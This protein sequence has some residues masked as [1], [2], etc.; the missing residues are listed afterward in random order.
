MDKSY[1]ILILGMAVVTYVPRLLPI[2]S[3]SRITIPKWLI[4]WLEYVPVAILSALLAPGI[5][6]TDGRLNITVDN[7]YLLAA[8][9]CFL[10]A[11]YKRSLFLIVLVGMVGMMAINNL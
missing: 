7:P 10:V 1:I 11:L 6:M 9:P 4:R 3:L 5:F 2:I 8:I